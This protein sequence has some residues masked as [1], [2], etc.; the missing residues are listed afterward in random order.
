MIFKY[1]YLIKIYNIVAMLIYTSTIRNTRIPY[2]LK[3][4]KVHTIIRKDNVS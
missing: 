2:D 4:L 1:K 3:I